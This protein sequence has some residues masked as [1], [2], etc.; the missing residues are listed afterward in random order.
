MPNLLRSDFM[1]TY[2]IRRVPWTC[3]WGRFGVAIETL[4]AGGSRVDDVFWAC[5]YPPD[6]TEVRLTRRGECEH[7]PSWTQAAHLGA[8]TEGLGPFDAVT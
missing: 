2:T 8:K 1:K 3:E 7:C 4:N 5:H 6:A